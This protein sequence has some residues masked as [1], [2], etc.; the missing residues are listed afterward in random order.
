MLEVVR[1]A[2]GAPEGEQTSKEEAATY[3]IAN[4]WGLITNKCLALELKHL[5]KVAAK[6]A[7]PA[8][9]RQAVAVVRCVLDLYFQSLRED[10]PATSKAIN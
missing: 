5:K 3:C 1:D 7:E 10:D 9:E 4:T 6:V 2:M 8:T